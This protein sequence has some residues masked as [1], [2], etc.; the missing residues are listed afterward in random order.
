[1]IILSFPLISLSSRS[2]TIGQDEVEL[3]TCATSPFVSK[4][5]EGGNLLS[6]CNH[7]IYLSMS[8]KDKHFFVMLDACW[9]RQP[10]DWLDWLAIDFLH[11]LGYSPVK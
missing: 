6:T 1:M 11:P 2:G 3:V 9:R 5:D 7:I 4:A 10:D 8:W